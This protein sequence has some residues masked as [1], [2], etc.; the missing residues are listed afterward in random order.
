MNS[1]KEANSDKKKVLGKGG[2]GGGG[3][4]A[5]AVKPKQ[6]TVSNGLNTKMQLST[7]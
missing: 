5:R 1:E 2:G 6:Q 7:Q 3:G 4:A